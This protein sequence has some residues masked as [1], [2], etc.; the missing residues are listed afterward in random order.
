MAAGFCAS[1]FSMSSPKTDRGQGQAPNSAENAARLR[2]SMSSSTMSGS[3]ARVAAWR[4]SNPSWMRKSGAASSTSVTRFS[5]NTAPMMGHGERPIR[6]TL[7]AHRVNGRKLAPV[8]FV[9]HAAAEHITVGQLE[10]DE[11]GVRARRPPRMALLREHRDPEAG[12][13]KFLERAAHRHQ[14]VAFVEDVVD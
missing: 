10:P 3:G 12:G 5:S 14:R 11:L 9:I 1:S 7:L 13:R 6:T 8:V 2:S 4:R